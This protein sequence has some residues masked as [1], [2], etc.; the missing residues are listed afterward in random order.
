MF[1]YDLLKMSSGSLLRGKTV[2]H[3]SMFES[4]RLHLSSDMETSWCLNLSIIV[5]VEMSNYQTYVSRAIS[6]G[7]SI[8]FKA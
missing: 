3:S 2:T 5:G 7:R 8:V 4:G 1:S 6:Y